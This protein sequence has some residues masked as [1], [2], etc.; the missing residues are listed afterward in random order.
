MALALLAAFSYRDAVTP[1][2]TGGDTLALIEESRIES[3]DDLQRVLTQPMLPII[4]KFFRPTSNL[5]YSMD[6]ALWGMDARGYHAT[7]VLLHALVCGLIVLLVMRWSG[8]LLAAGIA[9]GVF[10]LHPILMEVVPTP[11]RRQDMLGGLFV[12]LALLCLPRLDGE[13]PPL[14]RFVPALIACSLALGAKEA[15]VL[16]PAL[17]FLWALWLVERRAG[18]RPPWVAALRAAAPFALLTLGFV[19]WR[20]RVLGGAG[21][22]EASWRWDAGSVLGLAQHAGDFFSDLFYPLRVVFHPFA[23]ASDR[24]LVLAAALGLL[25]AI[26]PIRRWWKGLRGA[27]ATGA[28]PSPAALDLAFVL[29]LSVLAFA[30]LAPFVHDAFEQAYRREGWPWIAQRMGAGRSR[31]LEYFLWLAFDSARV[32]ATLVL[33]GAAAWLLWTTRRAWPEHPRL[34]AWMGAWLC[35]HLLLFLA[36][37]RYHAWNAYMPAIPFCCLAG[38]GFAHAWRSHRPVGLLAGGGI[39]WM[40][41]YSPLLRGLDVWKTSGEFNSRV[42]TQ[43]ERIASEV[44]AGSTLECYE[45]PNLNVSWQRDGPEPASAFTIN[46]A[47]L[48]SWLRL[49]QPE[50]RL[51]ANVRSMKSV[52]AP[53]LD[54]ELEWSAS[55]GNLIVVRPR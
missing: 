52:P 27:S 34:A 39:V 5:S 17:V 43:I 36:V 45:F 40:L 33:V 8:D 49:R 30:A 25:L 24:L 23:R 26:A 55:D 48:R 28:A 11:T 4:T 42:M 9:G 29:A 38:L 7:D 10:C 46:Q 31:P 15:S 12:L 3:L 20:A 22:N 44:P 13:R 21:G 2:F 54:L 19:L 18:T 14:R 41:A 37:Q 35:L 47:S 53:A 32:L 51:L 50:K 1:D 6:F 16:L